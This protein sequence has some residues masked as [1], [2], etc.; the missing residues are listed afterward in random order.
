[1]AKKKKKH[2]CKVTPTFDRIL[3][4]KSG[5][6]WE[7]EWVSGEQAMV[8]M[9]FPIFMF[10]SRGEESSEEELETLSGLTELLWNYVLT[11]NE[12]LRKSV[13]DGLNEFE[14][15]PGY[16]FMF[17][18]ILAELDVLF[19]DMFP[20]GVPQMG[21]VKRRLSAD[22]SVLAIFTNAIDPEY[23]PEGFKEMAGAIEREGL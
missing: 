20:E 21:K 10:G 9:T 16:P 7:F 5:G 12:E 15:I 18:K 11:D 19:K 14:S 8:K 23:L 4:R 3:G 2:K 17:T 22:T 1:M 6:E 13:V